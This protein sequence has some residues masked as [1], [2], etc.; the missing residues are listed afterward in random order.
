MPRY[1]ARVP[2]PPSTLP[3]DAGT[4]RSPLLLWQLARV[5]RC[6]HRAPGRTWAWMRFILPE[7]ASPVT[8]CPISHQTLSSELRAPPPSSAAPAPTRREGQS[9][10]SAVRG[11][12]CSGGA[13]A[14]CGYHLRE[15]GPSSPFTP[16]HST[17][18]YA[19]L[20]LRITVSNWS[21]KNTMWPRRCLECCPGKASSVPLLF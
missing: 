3:G 2:R 10:S 15:A 4:G 12:G 9:S 21:L 14:P 16:D 6:P 13:A 18:L 7:L 8:W 5:R 19:K 11:A 17:S 20:C 1:G